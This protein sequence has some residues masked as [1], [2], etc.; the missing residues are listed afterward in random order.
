[1]PESH[2]SI[3]KVYGPDG[4]DMPDERVIPSHAFVPIQRKVLESCDTSAYPERL[5]SEW[6]SV[7]REIESC[8]RRLIRSA[9]AIRKDLAVAILNTSFDFGILDLGKEVRTESTVLAQIKSDDREWEGF[10]RQVHRPTTFSSVMALYDPTTGLYTFRKAR[11]HQDDPEKQSVIDLALEMEKK[12]LSLLQG[13]SKLERVVPRMKRDDHPDFVDS[14]FIRGIT[15]RKYI[16]ALLENFQFRRESIYALET[17]GPFLHAVCGAIAMWAKALA[18]VHDA[19]Y[20]QVDTKSNNAMLENLDDD[21]YYRDFVEIGSPLTRCVLTD[22]GSMCVEGDPESNELLSLRK[23]TL[24]GRTARYVA[25]EQLDADGELS[26]SQ[27]NDLRTLGV[28]LACTIVSM[29]EGHL[30]YDAAWH[31]FKSNVRLPNGRHLFSTTKCLEYLKESLLEKDDVHRQ[32]YLLVEQ[33]LTSESLNGH[34]LYEGLV[35]LAAAYAPSLDPASL[36][37]PTVDMA[38]IAPL[39]ESLDGDGETDLGPLDTLDT[40]DVE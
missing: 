10:I 32:T 22:F 33:L 31:K 27:T 14:E 36:S 4:L 35:R 29:N 23:G 8:I 6:P 17:A 21:T 3:P 5:A 37:V 19:G 2:T 20:L 11:I 26:V 18:K 24:T 40:L 16:N 25:A 34:D 28:T 9:F 7:S 39:H 13:V 15:V 1:M 12:F 38:P 30:E